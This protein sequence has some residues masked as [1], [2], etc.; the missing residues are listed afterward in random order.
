MSKLHANA[1]L[2]KDFRIVVDNGRSHSVCLDLP[3]DQG[4]DMGPTALELCTMSY[5]G[6]YTTI[7]ALTAKKMRII[8]KE[9]NVAVEAVESEQEGTITETKMNINVKADAPLD[10]IRRIQ[11]LTIKNCPVGIILE[12]AGVETEYTIKTRKQ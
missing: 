12:K 7:F 8:L 9:L 10:R 11:E 1:S 3:L 6:C 5:A 2:I 4:S